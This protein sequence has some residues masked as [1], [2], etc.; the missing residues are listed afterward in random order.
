MEPS[1]VDIIIIQMARIRVC[2][3]PSDEVCLVKS[4]M[5]RTGLQQKLVEWKWKYSSRLE[6]IDSRTGLQN[7][8][9]MYECIEEELITAGVATR[10]PEPVWMNADGDHAEEG[11]S[12][13]CKVTLDITKRV[14][15]D[16]IDGNTS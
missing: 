5:H 3:C 12:F 4:M 15:T 7:F 8:S 13:G 6:H 16:E 2:I 11:D 14:V 10:L 1:V 9:Q